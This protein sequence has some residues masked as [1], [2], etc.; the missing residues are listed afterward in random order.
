M[1]VTVTYLFKAM[2]RINTDSILP[3]ITNTFVMQITP[4]IK[5]LNSA[6]LQRL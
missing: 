3:L 1:Y 5:T 2:K 4:D 6:W